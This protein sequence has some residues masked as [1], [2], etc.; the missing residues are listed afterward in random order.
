MITKICRHCGEPGP[1]QRSF[2]ADIIQD[3]K[4]VDEDRQLHVETVDQRVLENRSFECLSCGRKYPGPIW[5]NGL[6]EVNK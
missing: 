1:W 4:G 3:V 6:D 2:S 5:W